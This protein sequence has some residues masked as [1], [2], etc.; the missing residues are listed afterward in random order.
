MKTLIL[1]IALLGV[2]FITAPKEVKAEEPCVTI[3]LNCPDGTSHI[4]MV[5]GNYGG[6]IECLFQWMDILC[7]DND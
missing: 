2:F 7:G 4:V 1:A 6:K 5:C 3:V